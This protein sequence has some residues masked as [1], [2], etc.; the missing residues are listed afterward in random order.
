MSL[1]RRDFTK[2]VAAAAAVPLIPAVEL[3]ESPPVATPVQAQQ[4]QQVLP[5]PEAR[6]LAEYIRIKYGDRL[7]ANDFD[8]VT[9]RID[10]GLRGAQRLNDP[11]L[12]NGD[13][14]FFIY[15]AWRSEG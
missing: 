5:S 10:Q 8:A 13:E 6:A 11:K 1:S 15:R 2:T 3:A 14:P 9:R 7:S 4:Q 12:A